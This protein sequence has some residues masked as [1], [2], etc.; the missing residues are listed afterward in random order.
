[1]KINPPDR[2]RANEMLL[3]RRIEALGSALLT[4]FDRLSACEDAYD[5]KFD[6]A[7]EQALNLVVRE[8]EFGDRPSVRDSQELDAEWTRW[9]ERIVRRLE[10]ARMD[11]NFSREKNVLQVFVNQRTLSRVPL[12]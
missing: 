4:L 6:D 11:L 12:L 2:N 5:V 9:S 7:R 1:M 8:R 10:D 3:A